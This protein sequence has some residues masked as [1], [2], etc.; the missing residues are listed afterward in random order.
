M[1]FCNKNTDVSEWINYLIINKMNL[2]KNKLDQKNT[3]NE[4]KLKKKKEKM[5]ME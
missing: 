1:K 5:E 3:K 2:K 4:N